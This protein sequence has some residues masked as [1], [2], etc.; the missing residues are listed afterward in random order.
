MS[1]QPLKDP[2]EL[3]HKDMMA[4]LRSLGKAAEMFF[5]THGYNCPALCIIAEHGN[6]F[7]EVNNVEKGESEA[8]LGMNLERIGKA[9]QGLEKCI[10]VPPREGKPDEI[11]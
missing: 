5:A 6:Y 11:H 9:M 8:L 3:S 4:V 1:E 2:N 7:L 10:I